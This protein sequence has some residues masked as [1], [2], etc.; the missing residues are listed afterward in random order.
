[1]KTALKALGFCLGLFVAVWLVQGEAVERFIRGSVLALDGTSSLPTTCVNGQFRYDSST[2]KLVQCNSNTWAQISGSGGGLSYFDDLDADTISNVTTYDD[3]ASTPTDGTGGVVNY[4]STSSDTSTPLVGDASYKLSKSAN[5]AQG[6]GWA[7]DSETL[8][9]VVAGGGSAFWI[10]FYYKTSANYAADEVKVYAYR[11]GSNTLESLNSFQGSS[12]SN[13]LPVCSGVCEY[14]GWITASSSDTNI[15]LIF[16]IAGTAATAYDI[17][18]DRIR[19]GPSAVVQSGIQSDFE[20]VTGYTL[21]TGTGSISNATLTTFESRQG[22]KMLVVWSI[23]FTG[24][25]TWT[26]LYLNMRSGRTIDVDKLTQV[27]SDA[28]PSNIRP[29]DTGVSGY[30]P[31]LFTLNNST[32]LRFIQVGGGT[33]SSTS[34]FTFNSSD[35]LSGWFM[36]PIVGWT[37]GNVMSTAELQVRGVKARYTSNNGQSISSP[38][39]VIDFEDQDYDSHSIVSGSGTSWVCTIPID[40]TYRIDAK[41]QT[42]ATVSAANQYFIPKIY[43]NGAVVLENGNRYANGIQTPSQNVS[44]TLVLSKGDIVTIRLDTD[45]AASRSLSASSSSNSF[46]IEQLPDL[47]VLGVQGYAKTPTIQRLTSGSGTY[48]T[49]AGVKYLKIK[50][51]GGGGGGSGSGNSSGSGTAGGST[52][53]GTSLLACTGGGVGSAGNIAATTGGTAT[54]NSPAIAIVSLSGGSGA[55]GDSVA[56]GDGGIG[57]ASPFG[58]QGPGGT[59]GSGGANAGSSAV[60]NTGSGGGGGGAVAVSTGLGSGG[61]AGGYLEAIIDTPA[62]SYSYSVG[63]GGS[64]GGAGTSGYAGGAGG[65]GIIIVEEHYH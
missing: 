7:V 55:G 43:V 65:S 57:G 61:A 10:Q 40:G 20:E 9:S 62:P 49:P 18:L 25:S 13:S 39:Q 48:T 16:H 23:A 30:G 54:I 17:T 58:G 3:G 44:T 11:V 8:D 21:S 12:M 63:S 51:V 24:T 50:M 31:G 52:T 14:A 53:F 15:R 41:L 46:S 1:M 59:G 60:T 38:N 56:Q 35:S 47:T 37:S 33:F 19:G 28:I 36:V 45:V 27:G 29:L 64:G 34:P 26:D 22:D 32:Q 5:N 42:S 6:E 2:A 4:A